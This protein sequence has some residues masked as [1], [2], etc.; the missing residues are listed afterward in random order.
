MT[1]AE[2]GS[3]AAAARQLHMSPAAVGQAVA[4]LE[5]TFG[6]KLLSRTTRRMGVTADGRALLARSAEVVRELSEIERLFEERRGLI[7]GPL[8]VSAPLGFARRHVVPILARFVAEHP[9][10]E[11]SLDCSDAIRDFVG[12]AIDVAFRIL[13]PTDSTWIARRISQLPAVTLASPKYLREHG[14]PKHPRELARH[15]HIAYRYPV[16]SELAPLRFRVRGREI[17]VSPRAALTVN[18]VETGCEAGVLGLGIV[19][20]PAYYVADPL[21]SGA[22]VPILERYAPNPWTLYVCYPSAKH[23]PMRTRAFVNLARAELA[24]EAW[25]I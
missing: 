13:R 21:A 19:Q 22:L 24:R 15:V 25:V 16:T 8:R 2:L 14:V 6:V 4:R 10:V 17:S 3:F 1:S 9:G 20:P 7:A 23:V 12:D 5:Q 18:D 11:A